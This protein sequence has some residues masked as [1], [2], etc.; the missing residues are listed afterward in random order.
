M[1]VTQN[2][3]LFSAVLMAN[4]QYSESKGQSGISN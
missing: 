3:F 1:D 4:L 2:G